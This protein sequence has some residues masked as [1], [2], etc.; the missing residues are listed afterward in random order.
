M[1]PRCRGQ[2]PSGSAEEIANRLADDH[3]RMM[4]RYELSA[5]DPARFSRP[6]SSRRAATACGY[7]C[8]THF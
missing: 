5:N 1:R 7:R 4:R 8:P 3:Q 2:Q 6:S